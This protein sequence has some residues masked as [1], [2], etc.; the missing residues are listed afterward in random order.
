MN[1]FYNTNVSQLLHEL[2]KDE[3]HFLLKLDKR[4]SIDQ[5]LRQLSHHKQ[6]FAAGKQV[7][8]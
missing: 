7:L 8:K 3:G 5:T 6:R 2:K 4:T 1:V